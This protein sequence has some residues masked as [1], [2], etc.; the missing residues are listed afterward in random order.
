MR[1]RNT[2]NPNA[3]RICWRPHAYVG[4]KV[5]NGGFTTL[6]LFCMQSTSLA[7]PRAL[8][9]AREKAIRPF[10]PDLKLLWS[11]Q[12]KFYLTV[13]CGLNFA[14]ITSPAAAEI[15]SVTSCS[16]LVPF[17]SLLYSAFHVS[18]AYCSPAPVPDV[19][20]IE[21]CFWLTAML[22]PFSTVEKS[23]WRSSRR[24]ENRIC[25]FSGKL[26]EISFSLLCISISSGVYQ[27]VW[28][29]YMKRPIW[30]IALDN[31]LS[32]R[33]SFTLLPSYF[34]YSIKYALLSPFVL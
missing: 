2:E 33:I 4:T 17:T 5:A 16:I 21:V 1:W 11:N 14:Y 34:D 31:R 32:W 28:K 7:R 3:T 30:R 9:E 22:F 29:W 6:L 18:S 15:G 25:Y 12:I 27:R 20:L 19:Q 13:E 26:Y 24:F 23:A 10:P 8:W